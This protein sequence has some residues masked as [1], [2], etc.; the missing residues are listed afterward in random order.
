M[1]IGKWG[2]KLNNI[3]YTSRIKSPEVS[4]VCLILQGVG[5]NNKSNRV[6]VIVLG[7]SK[8]AIS[9]MPIISDEIV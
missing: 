2:N 7:W 4:H 9:T 3:Q 6:N 1:K 8:D 5:R